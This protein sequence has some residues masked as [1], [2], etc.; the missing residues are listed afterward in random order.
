MDTADF[1]FPPQFGPGVLST[2]AGWSDL[3]DWLAYAKTLRTLTDELAALPCPDNAG[4][5]VYVIHMPPHRM[6]L[7]VCVGGQRVGS[8][9]VYEFLEKVQP[10]LSLHGHIHESPALSGTW[11][12]T[13][14]HTVCVQPGQLDDFTYVVI[15]LESMQMERYSDRNMPEMV[16]NQR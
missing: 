9:A 10:T 6:G 7:D 1:V 12:A 11:R 3:P 15:D 5:R 16:A 14:G 4:P 8:R 2:P 13:L